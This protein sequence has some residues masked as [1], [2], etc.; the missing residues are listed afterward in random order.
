MFGGLEPSCAR[1]QGPPGTFL[2]RV[3]TLPR[4]AY[5]PRVPTSTPPRPRPPPPASPHPRPP[6]CAPRPHPASP[7]PHPAS[8]R[9]HPHALRPHV[10]VPHALRPHIH[11]PHA[12]RAQVSRLQPLLGPWALLRRLETLANLVMN[13]EAGREGGG[14]GNL[15]PSTWR[16]RGTKSSSVS[17][18]LLCSRA[19]PRVPTRHPDP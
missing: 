11:A 10:H 15:G 16:L 14:A 4:S 19:A 7:R 5:N 13:L 8:P 9:P 1:A 2:V 3:P 6:P 18:G 12:L 17:L